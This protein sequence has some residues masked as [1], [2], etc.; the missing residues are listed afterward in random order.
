MRREEEDSRGVLC[1]NSS[2]E[3]L[4]EKR[5]RVE[6]KLAFFR[7]LDCCFGSQ[8]LGN[9]RRN[10]PRAV[11]GVAPSINCSATAPKCPVKPL[12]YREAVQ[13]SRSNSQREPCIIQ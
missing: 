9:L 7:Q 8:L 12:Y 5:S 6:E 1:M 10:D 13:V 3:Q 11:P 2:F 4:T